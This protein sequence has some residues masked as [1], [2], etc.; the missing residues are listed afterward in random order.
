MGLFKRREEV[1]PWVPVTQEEVTTRAKERLA[2]LYAERI[3]IEKYLAKTGGRT[4]DDLATA[5][6]DQV[7]EV[8]TV[9]K[10]QDR[11][12]CVENLQDDWATKLRYPLWAASAFNRARKRP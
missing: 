7:D 8:L 2:E 11:L 9:L 3:E 10:K 4:K 6:P 5:A 12:V 1:K